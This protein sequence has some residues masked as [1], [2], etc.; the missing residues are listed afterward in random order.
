MKNLKILSAILTTALILTLTFASCGGGGG[1]SGPSPAPSTPPKTV[2]QQSVG[3]ESTDSDGN[4]YLLEITQKV[5]GKAAYRAA[6]IPVDGDTYELTIITSTGTI[7]KSK[8]TVTTKENG[9]ELTPLKS[10]GTKATPFNVTILGENMTGITGTITLTDNTP[11]PAPSILIQVEIRSKIVEFKATRFGDVSDQGESW[12]TDEDILLSDFTS[13]EPEFG[14]V[15]KFRVSGT[16]DKQIKWC[17]TQICYRD[18]SWK[19]YDWLGITTIS[20]SGTFEQTFEIKI[21]GPR[22]SNDPNADFYFRMENALYHENNGKA[23]INNARI[24]ANIPNGT[25]MAKIT[26]FKIRLLNVTPAL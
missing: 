19:T 25:V 18:D 17:E 1:G 8:G 7:K 16:T 4:T 9:F 5:S 3:F 26:N 14:Y 13:V 22:K 20:I 24:P 11:Q 12:T 6:Y 15:Y 23:Y 21:E 10:D 2:N